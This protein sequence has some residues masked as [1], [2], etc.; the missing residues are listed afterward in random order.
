MGNYY[1]DSE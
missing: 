1:E